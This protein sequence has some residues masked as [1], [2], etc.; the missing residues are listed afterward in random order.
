M[1]WC[2][3]LW[4]N[5]CS[6]SWGSKYYIIQQGSLLTGLFTGQFNTED[7]RTFTDVILSIGGSTS[8]S[9]HIIF[10]LAPNVF[11]N[12]ED[13]KQERAAKKIWIYPAPSPFFSI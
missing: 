7:S 1:V 5:A 10:I 3:L 6:G 2:Y 4:N 12:W 9:S 13:L 11:L 8:C